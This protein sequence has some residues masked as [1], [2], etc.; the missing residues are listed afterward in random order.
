MWPEIAEWQT[1]LTHETDLTPGTIAQYGKDVIR[2]A[3]W[4]IA[5][6][7]EI[8]PPEVTLSDAKAYRSWLL[9]QRRAP[10]T[11][12]RALVSL[13]RFYDH[14]HVPKNPFRAVDAIEVVEAAPQ[15]LTR[16]EW[17]RVRRAAEQ[18][19]RRDHGLALAVASL[20]RYAGLRI[21]EV[22]ALS[23]Q[24]VELSP[25]RGQVTIRQGKGRKH[26]EIPL[27]VEVRDVLH[28]YL[29][30][31]QNLADRWLERAF[32]LGEAAPEWS[33]WPNGHLFIGQRGPLKERGIREII[34]KIGHQAKLDQ[35]LHPH[36]LRHTFAKALLDPQAYGLERPP[37]P[38]TAVQELLGHINITT[39]AIYTR[40]SQADLR[41]IMGEEL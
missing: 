7:P 22:T 38:I 27:V 40:N 19:Q 10:A 5:Q 16:I 20:M 26:R 14:L 1:L 36:A 39:T 9:S 29:S 4:L 31:R 11:I 41:R 13:G 8:R 34:A 3:A 25:R 6:E 37:A 21:S 28:E 30:T 24:D 17:N 2:F 23:I 12:N 18:L 32:A 35:L 15:A 33:N